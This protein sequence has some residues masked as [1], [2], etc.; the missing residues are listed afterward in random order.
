MTIH[1]ISGEDT[2]IKDLLAKGLEYEKVTPTLLRNLNE[3]EVGMILNTY[4]LNEMDNS[5]NILQ[6][7][8]LKSQHVLS[9]NPQVLG[10]SKDGGEIF[11]E[12]AQSQQ[13]IIDNYGYDTLD[14]LTQQYQAF[15]KKGSIKAVMLTNKLWADLGLLTDDILKLRTKWSE[16]GMTAKI[17]DFIVSNNGVHYIVAAREMKSYGKM[18][19]KGNIFDM[20]SKSIT[21]ENKNNIFIYEPD[22]IIL[23]PK[24]F[25][26]EEGILQRGFTS[27]L[28]MKSGVEYLENLAVKCLVES[29]PS[30]K[31][32]A[33]TE[34]RLPTQE[35]LSVENPTIKTFIVDKETKEI[36]LEQ[37][38]PV[39]ANKVI[40]RNPNAI[41]E[42][43]GNKIYNEWPQEIETAIKSY[44][45]EAIDSL[46]FFFKPYK[47]VAAVKIVKLDERIMDHLGIAGN[48]LKAKV[49]WSEN[50][51]IAEVGKDFITSS[52]YTLGEV[53]R[54]TTY[55]IDPINHIKKQKIK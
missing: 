27:S 40:S 29:A 44:G 26:T 37:E 5:I 3:Q 47:K 16:D 32:S 36:K 33:V 28:V 53:E 10:I 15:Q 43:N 30:F 20:A 45:E 19:P 25:Y 13:S 1:I 38:T 18:K 12:W 24:L 49:S 14:K 42:I 6:R 11:N 51:M 50:P 17:N 54:E 8:N 7:M 31:K 22:S 35:E 41:G 23:S 21:D 4:V 48:I 46:S 55:D 39:T 9:R 2:Y 52:S 34:L